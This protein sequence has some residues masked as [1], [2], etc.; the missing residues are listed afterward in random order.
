MHILRT[1]KTRAD[2]RQTNTGGKPKKFPKDEEVFNVKDRNILM[3][4]GLTGKSTE[5]SLALNRPDI[6]RN[7]TFSLDQLGLT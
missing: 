3:E 5:G 4:S 7:S 1:G 6:K 2:L